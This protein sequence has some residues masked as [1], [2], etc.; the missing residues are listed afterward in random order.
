M[1]AATS[2]VTVAKSGK[3]CLNLAIKTLN[4][5]RIVDHVTLGCIRKRIMHCG[6][7]TD[8]SAEHTGDAIAPTE[9]LDTTC[10]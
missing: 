5:I 10:L 6:Y 2:E 1:M 8:C 7:A 9:N 4:L 3:D